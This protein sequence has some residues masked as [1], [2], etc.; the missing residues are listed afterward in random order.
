MP[1]TADSARYDGRVPY[2]RCGASGL[3]LPAVSLGLWH[4]FGQNASYDDMRALCTTA[5]DAGITHFDLANNYGPPYGAAE[6]NFGR[7][8]LRELAPYRDELLISTT[9]G[10]DMWDGPYGNWG[11][12]KHLTASL[13]QS[14]RRRGCLLYTSLAQLKAAVEKAAAR[15]P[16]IATELANIETRKAVIA[17]MKPQLESALQQA[18]AGY[19]QL[20]SGKMTAVNEITKGEVTLSSTEEKLKEAE[21]QLDSAEEQFMDARDQAYKQASLDGILT[22]ELLSN[23]LMAQNFSMPAGYITEG[24]EQYLLKVGDAFASVQELSLIHI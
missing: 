5:F 10:Y 16:E 17:A 15:L 23:L 14:L 18:Q 20:E 2:C 7:L 21:Q 13:D 6:E 9:A 19:A 24:T 12:R 1:Y 4:N 8:F 11:S 3:L 22:P